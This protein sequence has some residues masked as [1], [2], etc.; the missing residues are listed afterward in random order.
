M[1]SLRHRHDELWI[2]YLFRKLKQQQILITNISGK[3][4]D[5]FYQAD[6]SKT[7]IIYFGWERCVPGEFSDSL[8][9]PTT[10]SELGKAAFREYA[11]LAL[12]DD[13]LDD[14][15]RFVFTP[16]GTACRKI[17]GEI[18]PLLSGELERE[19]FSKY[20]RKKEFS[21]MEVIDDLV[22][23]AVRSKSVKGSN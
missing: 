17:Y 3:G 23:Y 19:I 16:D 10:Y 13:S 18:K 2:S 6:I 1:T 11:E 22:G 8:D 15:L 9:E 7:H 12:D 14:R 5:P 20:S 21:A 4:E